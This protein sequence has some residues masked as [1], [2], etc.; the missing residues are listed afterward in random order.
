MKSKYWMFL[1]LLILVLPSQLEALQIAGALTPNKNEAVVRIG[2]NVLTGILSPPSR[3]KHVDETN[4]ARLFEEYLEGSYGLGDVFLK[5]LVLNARFTLFQ[6]AKETVSGTQIHSSDA[7][8]YLSLKM[9]GN[10][11]HDAR[12]TFG[13]WLQTD[14]PIGMEK[15]K[16]VKPSVN[17]IGG[18]L[19][20]SGEVLNHFYLS[21]TI[22]LGSGL[23]SPRTKNTN[24]IS[25]TLPSVN[26]GQLLFN[27]DSVFTTGLAVEADLSSRTDKAYGKSALAN[28]KIKNLVFASPFIFDHPISE[29]L[30]LRAGFAAKWAG[31]SARGSMFF[32]GELAYKF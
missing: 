24:L 10:F 27:F 22:F 6:S 29:H 14:I 11:I 30:S 5:D 23:F 32:N 4:D 12:F 20:A 21:Q 18:G 15:K 16:F 28:G 13:T 19:S 26:W 9:A 1:I 17:Y 2:F 3:F 25:N 31:K 8:S 7:G